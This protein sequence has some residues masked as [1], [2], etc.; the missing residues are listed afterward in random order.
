MW[1][2]CLCSEDTARK[3]KDGLLVLLKF[4]S[5]HTPGVFQSSTVI[6]AQQAIV[7]MEK[8]PWVRVF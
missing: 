6:T 5:E 7:E 1:S 8:E 2:A 4:E 3:S